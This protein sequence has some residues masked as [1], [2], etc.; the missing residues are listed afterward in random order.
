[1]LGLIVEALKRPGI[2]LITHLLL[3]GQSVGGQFLV[4]LSQLMFS[5][6]IGAVFA[7]A[8][9]CLIVEVLALLRFVIVVRNIQQ[10]E[11]HFHRQR[12]QYQV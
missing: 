8:T 3:E 11:L 4:G 2:G 9:H 1:M 10:F 6:G 12:L 7:K 5:V